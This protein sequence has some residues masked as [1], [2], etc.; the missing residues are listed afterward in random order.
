VEYQEHSIGKVYQLALGKLPSLFGLHGELVSALS[1]ATDFGLGNCCLGQRLQDMSS[2]ERQRIMLLRF[3]VLSRKRQGGNLYVLEDPLGGL[4]P[5]YLPGAFKMLR[6]IIKR[7]HA[8]IVFSAFDYS[9]IKSADWIVELDESK[10]VVF[11]DFAF[12]YQQPPR[13]FTIENY[14]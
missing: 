14:L 7:S 13:H 2:T 11:S 3:G 1:V 10:G 6:S 8:S 9:V 4:D 5:E 12:S